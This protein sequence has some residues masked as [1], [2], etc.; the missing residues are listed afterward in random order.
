LAGGR[1]TDEAAERLLREAGALLEGHF[2]LS[3]GRHSGVYVEKFRLLERP[4]QTDALCRMIADWARERSP[5]VVA[6]PTTGGLIVSYEVAK[7]LGLRSIFAEKA[8]GGG[9]DGSVGR[10]FQRGF[11]IA[12]GERVLVVDDV[13][14]TGG[15]IR[16]V[17]DAVRA[18]GGEPIAVAVLIDRSGSSS[19]FSVPSFSCLALD[20][21][22]YEPD[23]CPLCAQKLPLT[24]T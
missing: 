22:S 10:S 8:E 15:S 21:P 2:Q 12:P 23:D 11:V 7:H 24:I 5:Q 14:T 19:D 17:L 9:P 4:P 16:D 6:G 20:L 13:L 3:S 18:M 1:Q